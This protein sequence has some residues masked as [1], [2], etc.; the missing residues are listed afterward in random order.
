M[1]NRVKYVVEFP[2]TPYL[3][4]NFLKLGIYRRNIVIK[5]HII[6]LSEWEN[7]NNRN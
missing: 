2:I 3:I 5:Q 4:R 6:L 7:Q 1:Y